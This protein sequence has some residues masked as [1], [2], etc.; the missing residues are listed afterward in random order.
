M[1]K[2]AV[3]N[4]HPI[5]YFAP[6]Y[7]ELN[8]GHGMEVTALYLSDLNLKPS[9]DPG[10]KREIKWDVNMLEGYNYKFIGKYRSNKPSGFWS[11]VVPELWT[12]IRS[13]DYDAIWLHGYNFA[14]YFVAF[15]AAKSKG[16]KIFFRGESHLE[17]IRGWL[18]SMIHKTFCK[19]F[20]RYIDV[21]LA[22]GTAN[23]NYYKSFGIDESNI[24]LVP[25]TIDNSRFT[26]NKDLMSHELDKLKVDIGLSNNP[27]IIFASKFMARKRPQDLLEAARILQKEGIGF[28]ILFVGSGDLEDTLHD[29]VKEYNLQNIFFQGFVNQT[30]LPLIYAASDIFVLPSIN[31]PWGLVINE[32]MSCGLPIII[33]KGIGAADDLVREGENG[34]TFEPLNSMD[35]SSKLKTMLEDA[36]LRAKMS[37]NSVDII[38]LWTYSQ[39]VMGIKKA[40]NNIGLS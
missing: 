6:L 36:S 14:A 12:E 16:I 32:V 3:I 24:F 39:C 33:A 23:K 9:T 19:I 37:K 38:N 20:F 11:L 5:Q 2:I 31:E 15:F 22:I 4:S 30:S 13:S 27:T 7:K 34:F 28:N 1:I 35:L 18:N 21:F 40:C 29:L 10:F 17:L 8:N 25:Y 26:I